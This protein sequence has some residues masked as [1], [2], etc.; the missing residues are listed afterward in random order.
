MPTLFTPLLNVNHALV[1]KMLL[2]HQCDAEK[3]GSFMSLVTS[4]YSALADVR[5]PKVS[6]EIKAKI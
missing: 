4:S 1:L 3:K 5:E 2:L 6:G